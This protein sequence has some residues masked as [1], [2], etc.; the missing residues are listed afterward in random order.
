MDEFNSAINP[1]YQRAQPPIE[2]TIGFYLHLAAYLIV[3]SG[4]LLLDFL[5]T[6]YRPW[7]RGPILGGGIGLL[8]HALAVFLKSPG[9]QWKRRTIKRE[10]E[11]T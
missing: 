1:H 4:L 8:F 3:N 10:L 5:L 6:P 2:R 7:A 9:A 11:K